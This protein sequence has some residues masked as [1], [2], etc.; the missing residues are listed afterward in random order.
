MFKRDALRP[1]RLPFLKSTLLAAVFLF[2]MAAPAAFAT[3]WSAQSD[4]SAASNPNGVWSYGWSDTLAG[5][6]H[7]YDKVSTSSSG[8]AWYDPGNSV[9]GTPSVWKNTGSST[10]YGV[11]PGDISLAPGANYSDC[12]VKWVSPVSGKI[13]IG[14]MFGAG[15]S[16]AMSYYV[17][18]DGVSKYQWLNASGDESF[19]FTQAVSSGDII[20]FVVGPS[21]GGSFYYGNTPLNVTIQPVPEPATFLLFGAGLIEVAILR[22]K[23]RQ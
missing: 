8:V 11:A 13:N 3:T 10:S 18:V 19:N 14:G 20:D 6:L 12:I 23:S 2:L 17:S 4:F 16:G 5:T 22:K 9:L 21:T 15:D 1:E 7:L